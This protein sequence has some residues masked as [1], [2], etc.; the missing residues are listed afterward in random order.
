[1]TDVERLEQLLVVVVHVT[2]S[3]WSFSKGDDRCMN[4]LGLTHIV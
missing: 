4:Y 2:V 1:M 3:E